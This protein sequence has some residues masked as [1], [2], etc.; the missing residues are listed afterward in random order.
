MTDEM[1]AWLDW[2]LDP[3]S[4]PAMVAIVEDWLG[5]RP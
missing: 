3:D 1:L 4:D 2:V 5:L